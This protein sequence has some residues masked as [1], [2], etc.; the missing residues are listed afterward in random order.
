[1]WHANVYSTPSFNSETFPA[2]MN[3]LTPESLRNLRM[4]VIWRHMNIRSATFIS[5]FSNKC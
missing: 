1:M 4:L 3:T 2:L 5:D